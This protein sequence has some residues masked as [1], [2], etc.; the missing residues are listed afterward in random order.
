MNNTKEKSLLEI[1]IEIMGY[2]KRPLDIMTI[3]DQA[4]Q[5]KDIKE[6][7]KKE[8]LPRFICDI[9]E[10]GAFVYCGNGQW[11]LKEHQP[12]SV[13][14]KEVIDFEAFSE[15]SKEAALNE[16]GNENIDEEGNAITDESYNDESDNQSESDEEDDD[17]RKDL[18]KA[19]VQYVDEVELGEDTVSLDEIEADEDED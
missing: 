14:E 6:A 3:T 10:S 4:M 8:I 18:E 9:M 17:L 7:A 1:A 5:E 16:L 12:L 15:S 11:D 19:G 2:Q 13:L